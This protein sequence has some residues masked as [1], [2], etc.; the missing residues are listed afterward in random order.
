[1]EK[2]AEDLNRYLS[3]EGVQMSNKH[4]KQCSTSL[5]REMQIKSTMRYHLIPVRMA[6][7]NKSKGGRERDLELGVIRYNLE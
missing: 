4:M 7:I 2:W 6:I 5:I 3:K 1:M